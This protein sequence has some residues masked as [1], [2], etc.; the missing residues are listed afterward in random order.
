MLTE[1]DPEGLPIFTDEDGITWRKHDDGHVD[2]WDYQK[3]VW[4]RFD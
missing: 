4:V 2:W 3:L 1:P